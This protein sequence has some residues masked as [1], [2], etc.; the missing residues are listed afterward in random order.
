M[1]PIEEQLNEIVKR[2]E[3]YNNRR[4]AIGF[5]TGYAIAIAVCVAALIAVAISI[6]KLTA[7]DSTA[8]TS[9]YGSLILS[10]P[11]MGYVIVGII[12]FALGILVALLCKQIR[13]LNLSERKS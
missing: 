6:P 8:E 3:A 10:A 13:E 9:H 4:S 1:R 11:Y 7:V 12:A 5:I 2:K